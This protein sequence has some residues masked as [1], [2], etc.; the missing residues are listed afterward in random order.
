MNTIPEVHDQER[1]GGT[2]SGTGLLEPRVGGVEGQL[3][4]PPSSAADAGLAPQDPATQSLVEM[5]KEIGRMV[6]LEEWAKM[7]RDLSMRVGKLP[8]WAPGDEGDDD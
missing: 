8:P 4:A 3:L 7:P 1:A 5:I 2:A 6:P